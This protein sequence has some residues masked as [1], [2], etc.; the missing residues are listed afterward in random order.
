[1]TRHVTFM[2]I[3]DVTHYTEE[4]KAAIIARY[5]AHEREARSKGIPVFGGGRVFPV[6]E[7]SIR[8]DPFAIPDHWGQLN[9]VDFG[10]DHPFAAV[11]C[12]YDRDAD[13]FYVT[14]EYRQRETTPII[15]AAAIKPWG[16]W[17]PNA[18]PHDGLQHDKGAGE[19]LAA[20]YADQ[21]LE[22]MPERATFEDGSFSVEAGVL[23]MLDRMLTGRFKVFSSCGMWFGEMRLYH[24]DE[25]TGL[26]VKENDDLISASRYAYMMR[27][28]AVTKPQPRR[29]RTPK[30]W[31]A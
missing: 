7:E 29:A 17:V 1:M 16:E 25:D 5:P 3:D 14:K 20:Q 11:N 18:W 23:E 24:R 19:P 12:A 22:M 8:V 13:V 27:R 30:G 10:W 15:H 26:I 4:Q 28:H 21:G 9:G 31:M 2:T 6:T